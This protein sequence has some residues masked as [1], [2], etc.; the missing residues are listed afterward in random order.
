[1]AL[2][3]KLTQI[4]SIA[5]KEKFKEKE[6]YNQD[7]DEIYGGEKKKGSHRNGEMDSKMRSK[8]GGEMVEWRD[9]LDE[10]R[11]LPFL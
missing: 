3:T 1:M 2:T 11:R 10:R 5:N 7:L 9:G 4:N 6:R 8:R